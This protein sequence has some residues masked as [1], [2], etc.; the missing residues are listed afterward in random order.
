MSAIQRS[1]SPSPFWRSQGAMTKI[2]GVKHSRTSYSKSA[3]AGISKTA[4][5][6]LS[7]T[8]TPALLPG[9][10]IVEFA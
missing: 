4:G 3:K 5:R 2:G 7:E 1:R 9:F 10:C 6:W 8:K